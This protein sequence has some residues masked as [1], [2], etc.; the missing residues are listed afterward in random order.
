MS[1]IVHIHELAEI[2]EE[3]TRHLKMST[4]N[5]YNLIIKNVYKVSPKLKEKNG[6][7]KETLTLRLIKSNSRSLKSFVR[8]NTEEPVTI[9]EEMVVLAIEWRSWCDD[10]D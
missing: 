10:A 4:N 6:R 3:I 9:A 7:K 8:M 1:E 2:Q 5:I